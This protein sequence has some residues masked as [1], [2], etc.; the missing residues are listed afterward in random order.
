[1]IASLVSHCSGGAVSCLYRSVCMLLA[2]SLGAMTAGAAE[3]VS[4]AVAAAQSNFAEFLELLRIPNIPAEPR[5]IQRNATFL[6]QSFRKRGFETR[7]LANAAQRPLVF[8]QFGEARPGLRTVLFYAHFDGQPVNA[9][10][11]AQDSPFEP[12]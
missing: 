1:M 3:R 11:W 2:G 8:A 6:E 5:D 10:E 12:V 9:K 7:L 4:P